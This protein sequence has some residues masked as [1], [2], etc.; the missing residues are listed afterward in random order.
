ML[1]AVAS[2]HA[3]SIVRMRTVQS[4]GFNGVQILE[5]SVGFVVKSALDTHDYVRSLQP[6]AIPYSHWHLTHTSETHCNITHLY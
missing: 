3:T 1:T 5:G 6:H 2:I 4:S